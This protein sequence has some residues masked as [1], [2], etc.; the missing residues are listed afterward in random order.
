M[1][2]YMLLNNKAVQ[3]DMGSFQEP[4]RS[5]PII[6]EFDVLVCGGGHAGDAAVEY[7]GKLPIS[8]GE[9]RRY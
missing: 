1:I 7:Q 9:I 5:I 4:A 3:F 6:E 2:S 8:W